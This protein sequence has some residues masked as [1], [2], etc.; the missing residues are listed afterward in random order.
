MSAAVAKLSLLQLLHLSD[1]GLPIGSTAHS[2]GLEMMTA[3]EWVCVDDLAA[4]LSAHL[5]ENGLADAIFCRA[6]LRCDPN[7]LQPLCDVLSA[8]RTSSELRNASTV[9][10]RRLL[11]LASACEGR[12][13]FSAAFE[14]ENFHHAICFG[15]V[16]G[17][18]PIEADDAVAA[19]LHQSAAALISAAQRLLP[20]GQ[21][22]AHQILWSLKPQIEY[23][24]QRSATLAP[25]QA[26][27]FAPMYELASMRH[28][29]L[30]TRL[31]IS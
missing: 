31:F 19:F 27:T 14:I 30:L 13:A 29:R 11:R 4:F 18:L 1:S 12:P 26:C 7:Q 5:E 21:H 9:M 10:G 20:L 16:A 25:E 17:V 24:A 2:F 28:K 23:I 22:L 8:L 3:L 6:A 15:F